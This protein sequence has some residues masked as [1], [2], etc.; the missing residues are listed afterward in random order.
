LLGG[1]VTVRLVMPDLPAMVDFVSKRL[2][3]DPGVV[4]A[5]FFPGGVLAVVDGRIVLSESD[6]A[7]DPDLDETPSPDALKGVC[8]RG[9]DQ[10]ITDSPDDDPSS[11]GASL[12]FPS[13]C[14]GSLP[15]ALFSPRDTSWDRESSDSL[16]LGDP[17]GGE[18]DL[19]GLRARLRANLSCFSLNFASQTRFFGMVFAAAAEPV[20]LGS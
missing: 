6:P 10:G 9:R 8:L 16:G 19:L 14:E 11:M 7:S 4:L 5:V 1:V 18:S 2:R 13:C 3:A 12:V 17:G 15:P 20:S